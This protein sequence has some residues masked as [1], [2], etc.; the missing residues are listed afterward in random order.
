MLNRNSVPATSRVQ[1]PPWFTLRRNKKSSLEIRGVCENKNVYVSSVIHIAKMKFDEEGTKAQAVT[2]VEMKDKSC[3]REIKEE[4]VEF[5]ADRPFL[6]VL[7][8]I[9]RDP[10][11]FTALIQHL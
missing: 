3:K 4:I 5:R 10:I 8:P 6:V 1:S 11:L 2:V 7:R 9:K